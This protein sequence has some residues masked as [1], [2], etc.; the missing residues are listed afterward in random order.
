[1]KLDATL[2]RHL[3]KEDFRLLTAIEMGMKN[4][5]LV[6]FN[7]IVQISRHKAALA[8]QCIATIH[9]Q[10]LVWHDSVPYDGYKLTYSGYDFLA[11]RTFAA[12][13]TVNA[14]G[15]Q[16]GVGKESDIYFV[17][18]DDY[19]E[20]SQD[21]KSITTAKSSSSRYSK[22][23]Q[24]TYQEERKTQRVY[25]LKLQRLGRVSF[26]SIKNNR[27]Y[28]GKRKNASWLYISRIA[29]LKE[30]AFMKALYDH[31]FPTPRPIDWNRHCVVMT[32]VDGFLLYQTPHFPL[33]IFLSPSSSHPFFFLLV[34]LT[35]KR[36]CMSGKYILI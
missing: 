30:Y 22:Y 26:K 34:E 11:L 29:A 1:M 15:N 20:A 36:S 2:L 6:P 31:G 23:S 14:V 4:H 16:I 21:N 13:G 3:S 32:Q 28:M 5:Q 25:V 7:L 35:S 17:T 33:P 12:R 27:D 8:K 9:R 18:G 19:E 10:K 24:R